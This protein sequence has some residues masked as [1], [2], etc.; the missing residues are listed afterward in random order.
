MPT[1]P[2]EVRIL[3]GMF[4][5]IKNVVMKQKEG[6]LLSKVFWMIHVGFFKLRAGTFD[7]LLHE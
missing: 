7:V 6:I 3:T 1:L 4:I 2:A 5:G